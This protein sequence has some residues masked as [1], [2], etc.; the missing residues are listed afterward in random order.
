MSTMRTVIRAAW[1][2]LLAAGLI[3]CGAEQAE[4]QAASQPALA[5][6]G[7][8]ATFPEP[9]Y[10]EWLE[11][12]KEGH[13]EVAFAY[14]GVGSGEGIKRFIGGEVDFG[15]SDAAMKDEEI[16]RVAG[17]VKM[18]PV[19]AGMIVLAYNLPGMEG[20]LRLPRDVY[21]DIFQARIDRWDDPRIKAA[22]P[23]LD[24]PAK[25]IQPI[26]RRDS[27]GTTFAFTNHLSAISPAWRGEGPGTGKLID[28]PGA[29][30]TAIG[31][32]GVAH[33]VQISH[34]SIGYM[35]YGFA[36]RLELPV[37]TLQNQAGNYVAPDAESGRA[38]LAA[39]AA[40][41]PADLRLFIPD[42]AGPD[43]YPIVSLSWI[44]LH[45]SYGDAA[46]AAALKAA[47]NRGLTEGQSIAEEMGYIPLPEE[48]VTKAS[49]ALAGIR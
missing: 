20:E 34:G 36:R 29:A 43:S 10:R 6:K 1:A 26:V 49:E 23:R 21:A 9:L 41:L 45:D 5:I 8:G 7:A 33:K 11:R 17:A 37:A 46:K 16:A 48:I 30:M 15:A 32:E 4:E 42:P 25:L 3:S 24:L 18:I 38:A 2:L 14:E 27:S 22:N 19:T 44:L 40:D 31:N 39:A 12:Y 13:P 47:L 35:E 28:W